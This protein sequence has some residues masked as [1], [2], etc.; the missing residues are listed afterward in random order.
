M[1]EVGGGIMWLVCLLSPSGAQATLLLQHAALCVASNIV[2]P[3]AS[4]LARQRGRR[5]EATL[6][7]DAP[8]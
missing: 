1:Q 3:F 5:I 8:L 6:P 7:I 4:T 2:F